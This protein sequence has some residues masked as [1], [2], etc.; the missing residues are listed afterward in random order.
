MIPG[1]RKHLCLL[2]PVFRSGYKSTIPVFW[3]R[4]FENSSSPVPLVLVLSFEVPGVVPGPQ[5]LQT[6]SIRSLG[7]EFEH[8]PFEGG[9]NK[10]FG[11]LV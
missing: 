2:T 8:S 6:K 10:G 9:L 1:F 11:L 3:A 4:P 5:I 7:V